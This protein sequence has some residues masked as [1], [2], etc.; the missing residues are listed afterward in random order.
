M[1]PKDAIYECSVNNLL[2]PPVRQTSLC[3]RSSPLDPGPVSF[4]GSAKV[5][6]PFIP[7]YYNLLCLHALHLKIVLHVLDPLYIYTRVFEFCPFTICLLAEKIETG[8]IS[9]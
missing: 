7:F 3:A 1:S 6:K 8:G 9:T 5:S 2:F 4:S